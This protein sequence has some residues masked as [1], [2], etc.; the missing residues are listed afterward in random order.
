M[1]DPTS[2]FTGA[3]RNLLP[4]KT[5][6]LIGRREHALGSA[7]RLFYEQ[8]IEFVRGSGTKLYDADGVEYLDVYNNVQ[9]VGHAHPRVTAAISDQ[10]A[11]LNTHT[12]YLHRGIVDYSEQLLATMPAVLDTV[13]YACTGSEANDLALRL[14]KHA[15]GRRGV[16]VTANA[17]HGTSTEV[18]AISPS[19]GGPSSIAEWVR[20]VPAPWGDGTG[21]AAEITDA[22]ASLEAAG[23][24]L[25][26][27]VT[28]TIFSSDG[29]LPGGPAGFLRPAVDAA[30]AAGG[31]FIADE[32][33]AG[34]GR[35]GAGMWGFARHE[36]VPDLVTLG[37]P[38][39]NGYPVAA[40]VAHRA[41]VDAFGHDV[42]Y[43]NTFGGSPVQIA[44]AQATLNVLRD[45]ALIDNARRVGGYLVDGILEV[46]GGHDANVAVRGAG[47][48]IGVDLCTPD[49]APDG[50][51][52]IAVVNELRARRVLIS[53][54]GLHTN[55]LKVRPPLPFSASDADRFLTE[56]DGALSA[57]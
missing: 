25:A 53:A 37:K 7:Y 13:M 30:H 38:M 28:D 47:L 50:D 14:A 46:A 4:E 3:Q 45:E 40:V 55:V 33:Q 12:R 32:V 21:W 5:R 17:Y 15:T 1:A 19:L 2:Y 10:S 43:F 22:I 27:L 31:L 8:P 41:I 54:S 39:G 23:H 18:A 35:L 34:F 49:G 16:I 57:V 11:L 52:A 26:A 29:V 20:I 9:S 56:L 51:R 42:R 44:A 36:V 6:D 48:F 24:G